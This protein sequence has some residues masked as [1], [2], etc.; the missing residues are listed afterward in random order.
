MELSPLF[1]DQYELVMAYNYWKLGRAESMAVFHLF[2]RANPFKGNYTICSGINK[3]IEFINNFK[4]TDSDLIYLEQ[5][6]QHDGSKLFSKDFL[7]YL[8]KLR[9]TGSIHA[10]P[11]GTISFPNE[12]LARIE[13]PITQCILFETALINFFNFNSLI[14][15]KASRIRQVAG[16]DTVIEFGLR[17]AQGPDGGLSASRAAY[18][19]GCDGTSNVIAGK[20]YDIPIQGTQAHSW[21]MS[22][23]NELEAFQQHSRVRGSDTVLLVDTY[24]TVIGIKNAIKVARELEKSGK[25]LAGIRL[26]SGDLAKLSRLSRQ[27][28]D[29]AGLQSVKIL[30]SGDLDEYGIKELKDREAPIDMWGVGTQLVTAF[31]EPAMNMVY[32]LGQYQDKDGNWQAAVKL[33]DNPSKNSMPGCHQVR[34]YS[35]QQRFIREIIYDIQMGCSK[36][37]PAGADE[38]K[39]LLI[40]IYQNGQCVYSTPTLKDIRAYAMSQTNHFMASNPIQYRATIEPQLHRAWNEKIKMILDRSSNS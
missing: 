6:T 40:P 38:C 26:D 24:N 2:F 14:A 23:E 10:M 19:G 22:F 15:T 36:E 33:S 32:K 25:S 8:S 7:S 17:R 5:Q 21:I 30:A 1:T 35:N 28:L 9:F 12:P 34:R 27:M 37:L 3:V 16:E 29:E 11:E 18:I 31:D 4:F 39:D 20:L 13:A